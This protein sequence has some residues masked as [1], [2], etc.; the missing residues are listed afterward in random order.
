MKGE[1]NVEFAGKTAIHSTRIMI[2]PWGVESQSVPSCWFRCPSRLFCAG[3][4]W[5]MP[6][7]AKRVR[8]ANAF[9][10]WAILNRQQTDTAISW[11][12]QQ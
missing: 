5:R 3:G 10:D 1:N 7:F 4:Y 12:E 11:P 6:A 9:Q 8:S 2:S